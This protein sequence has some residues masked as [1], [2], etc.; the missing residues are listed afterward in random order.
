V[1]SR[2]P[3]IAATTF[4][5]LDVERL[6][7]LHGPQGTPYGKNTTAGAPKHRDVRVGTTQRALNRQYAALSGQL[8]W[9]VT[10]KLSIEP[11]LRLNHDD[12]DGPASTCMPMC[13]HGL[14]M[15]STGNTTSCWPRLQ[16]TRVSCRANP[17]IH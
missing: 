6:E 4:D 8:P 15:P 3:L 14:A 2:H 5:F 9:H 17:P 1:K 16:A 12:E 13:T 11:G 10:D 7:V